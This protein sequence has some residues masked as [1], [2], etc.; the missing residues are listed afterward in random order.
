MRAH[1]LVAVV[2]LSA[3]APAAAAQSVT[4]T[5][6]RYPIA[7]T[8]AAT[9]LDVLKAEAE[10][11]SGGKL[12]FADKPPLPADNLIA[13]IQQGVG[14]FGIV[15][16]YALA[17]FDPAHQIFSLPFVFDDLGAVL[18]FYN[19][20]GGQLLS[21]HLR[22]RGIESLGLVH[23]AMAAVVASKAIRIPEDAKDGKFATLFIQTPSAS[24]WKSLGVSLASTNTPNV[25]SML[26]A[27]DVEGY[28]G[29]MTA[30]A[31][32]KLPNKFDVL[33]A[34][35]HEYVGF[36]L[37]GSSKFLNALPDDVRSAIRTSAV[38][39]Q[40]RANV[41]AVERISG[42]SAEY[43]KAGIRV[44]TL[45]ASELTAWRKISGPTWERYE[46]TISKDIFQL[47]RASG[48]GGGGD[49]C[50]LLQ[51][52]RCADRTCSTTCCTR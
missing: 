24:L 39:A 11:R 17:R 38:E 15:S 44:V 30:I 18:R 51:E 20:K 26:M 35:R 12:R 45:K 50:P 28:V 3:T 48:T 21:Q 42:Q 47:A 25:P 14:E 4:A 23:D 5:A 29:P 33:T 22:E 49:P 36:V 27:G 8:P 7:N 13:A 40:V 31:A 9:A 52:C 43:K 32:S 19:G 37:I 10:K 6:F 34:T 16:T 1:Q 2:V 41:R 46:G